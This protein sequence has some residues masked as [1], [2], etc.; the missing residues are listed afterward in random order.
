MSKKHIEQRVYAAALKAH[1]Y[2]AHR[3]T[4]F[5][6]VPAEAI[7]ARALLASQE[8]KAYA[9]DAVHSLSM[10]LRGMAKVMAG[11]NQRID[12]LEA[13]HSE[14]REEILNLARAVQGL[15]KA[16][17]GRAME[18]LEEALAERDGLLDIKTDIVGLETG[19]RELDARLGALMRHTDMP[20][21]THGLRPPTST[22]V[23][24]ARLENDDERLCRDVGAAS[25]ERI[26][27]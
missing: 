22:D 9:D 17:A 4:A 13:V 1:T 8:A 27:T 3:I 5:R 16:F 18:N 12:T 21:H 10:A 15:E 7:E 6:I 20:A 14:T 25:D 23:T 11:M 26:Q 24:S 2:V 19:L